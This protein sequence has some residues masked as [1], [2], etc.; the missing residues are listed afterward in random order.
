MRWMNV[1]NKLL[2]ILKTAGTLWA[3]IILSVAYLVEA[4][5]LS[6]LV[7]LPFENTISYVVGTILFI[8]FLVAY[9]MALDNRHYSNKYKRWCKQM[10]IF[11]EVIG[12]SI[13]IFVTLTAIVILGVF[14][15]NMLNIG[16]YVGIGGLIFLALSAT[17]WY[18][19][20]QCF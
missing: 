7:V 19:Y 14:T 6:I 12:I 3:W 1:M 11:F 10:C 5:A 4:A 16:S 15:I 2:C 8:T 18:V 13:A 17:I 9:V 20:D